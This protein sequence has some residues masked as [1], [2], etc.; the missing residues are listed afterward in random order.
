MKRNQKAARGRDGGGR[1]DGSKGI[2]YDKEQDNMNSDSL[3]R[4]DDKKHKR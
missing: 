1:E 2:A 4:K 3:D